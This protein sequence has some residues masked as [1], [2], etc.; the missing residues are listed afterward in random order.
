MRY[1]RANL[2]TASLLLCSGFNRGFSAPSSSSANSRRSTYAHSI[3]D[4]DPVLIQTH[5]DATS[6]EI[7]RFAKAYGKQKGKA[8]R[9]KKG[10]GALLLW[11]ICLN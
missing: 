3:K 6:A 11:P 4:L 7:K 9:V 8:D 2:F 10:K 1:H 5:E